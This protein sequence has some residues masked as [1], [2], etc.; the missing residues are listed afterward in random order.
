M[1]NTRSTGP[2]PRDTVFQLSPVRYSLLQARSRGSCGQRVNVYF[3]GMTRTPRNE[4]PA[5][6]VVAVR[7]T[8]AEIATLRTVAT[9]RESLGQTLRRLA[10]LYAGVVAS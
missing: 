10:L 8:K 3:G 5:T 2:S 1:L 9:P 6:K 4:T 7:L